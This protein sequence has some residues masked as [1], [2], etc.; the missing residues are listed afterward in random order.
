MTDAPRGRVILVMKR[1]GNARVLDE[2]V[3]E[4][5]MTGVGVSSERALRRALESEG[6]AHA[7]LVDVSGFG[8]SVRE[9]C[10][11]LQ[12]HEVPF[13]VLSTPEDAA[14]GSCTLEYGAASVLQKP[15][16]RSALLALVRSLDTR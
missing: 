6:R 9:L 1:P 3:A 16:A 12:A 14:A 10:R 4:V 15:V 7:A 11:L 13:A 2:A 5:G 8:S